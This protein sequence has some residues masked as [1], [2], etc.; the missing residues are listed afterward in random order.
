MK[1]IVRN[2]GSSF[3]K[4]GAMILTLLGL[5]FGVPGRILTTIGVFFTDIGRL[6]DDDRTKPDKVIVDIEV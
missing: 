4:I 1:Y 5:V 2:A 3:K 6:L